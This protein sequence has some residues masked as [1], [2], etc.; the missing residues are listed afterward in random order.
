MSFFTGTASI[1]HSSPIPAGVTKEQAIAMLSDHAFF[2]SCDPLLSKFEP[3]SPAS[4]PVVPD[5][6]TAQ[7][8]GPRLTTCFT[9]TDIV[10]TIPAGLWDTN[11]VSTYEFTDITHG[12][13]A[14]IRSPLSVVLDTLWEIKEG[15]AGGLELVEAATIS[16]SRLLLGVVKSQCENGWQKI[17]AKML[18]RLEDEVKAGAAGSG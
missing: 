6:I 14:R 4:P 11:V 8:R 1:L 5:A 17:H 10:H 12:V 13:F 16:C 7:A 9:V 18:T 3:L 15:E 2:L